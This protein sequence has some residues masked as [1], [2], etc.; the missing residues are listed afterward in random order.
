MFGG[1]PQLTATGKGQTIAIVDAYGSRTIQNDLNVFD[2]QFGL[3]AATVTIAYP[4]GKPVKNDSGW[5]LE[6]SLDVEWAHSIAP[7]AKILLVVAKSASTSNLVSAIDYAT[8]HGAT[9]VSNSWGGSEFS[10]EASYDSHFQHTGVVYLASSGDNG[11]GTSWPAVSP[12]VVSVGGN[13]TYESE[14]SYQ[15]S[16]Q[17]SGKRGVPDVASDA[18]PNTG[19][20]VY[21]STRYQGQKGWYVVGGTSWSSPTWAAIF[22]LADE[23]RTAP[24]T[25]GLS[26]I[27]SVANSNYAGNYFDVTTGNNGVAATTGYDYVSGI[28]S[29]V[30]QNLVPALHAAQ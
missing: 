9:V 1:S 6:T 7:D 26:Q 2:Q 3:P 18:D 22:A 23:G 24:I 15:S 4:N 13:S 29:P 12:Y 20:A 30:G 17:S 5:A 16:W 28:G 8:S 19:A 10:S 27:Y 21:D 11:Y 14:P 25:G